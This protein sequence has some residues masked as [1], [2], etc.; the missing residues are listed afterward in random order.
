MIT[1]VSSRL[2]R[3]KRIL[4]ALDASEQS[5]TALETAAAL[6]QAMQGELTGL[7]VEDADLL[8]LA[9][10][11]YSTEVRHAGAEIH[12][13]DV[14]KLEREIAERSVH[15]RRAMERTGSERELRWRFRCVRGNVH[16]EIAA[17]SGDVD[18]ICIGRRIRSGYAKSQMGSMAKVVLENDAP[19]LISGSANRPFI[20]SVVAVFDGTDNTKDYLQNAASIAHRLKSDLVLLLT[21]AAREAPSEILDWANTI[22]DQDVHIDIVEIKEGHQFSSAGSPLGGPIGLIICGIDEKGSIP[23]WLAYLSEVH[24]CPLLLLPRKH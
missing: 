24:G 6:A 9:Q 12:H 11:P 22:S 5:L 20:G 3:L 13:L 23:G 2:G 18:L 1:T 10:L 17:A 15:A 7:F 14:P 21:D 8:T 16:R 19:V 4:V